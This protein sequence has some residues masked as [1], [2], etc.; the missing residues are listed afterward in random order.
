MPYKALIVSTLVATD[1]Q[2]DDKGQANG[3]TRSLHMAKRA[4]PSKLRLFLSQHLRRVCADQVVLHADIAQTSTFQRK[5][6][7]GVVFCGSPNRSG[8][9]RDTPDFEHKNHDNRYGDR[10]NHLGM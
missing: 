10:Q 6:D 5:D 9:A 3:S 4:N 8:R 7:A 2:C 1:P